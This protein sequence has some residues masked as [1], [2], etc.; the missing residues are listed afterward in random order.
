MGSGEKDDKVN[1]FDGIGIYKDYFYWKEQKIECYYCP[2]ITKD[3]IDNV[4]VGKDGIY[5]NPTDE[6]KRN[7]PSGDYSDYECIFSPDINRNNLNVQIVGVRDVRTALLL[8]SRYKFDMIFCD[9][10]L[11]KKAENSEERDYIKQLFEFLSHN[12]K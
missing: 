12:Y 10:L 7:R 11:D 5:V 4:G 8:M 9:Y 2:T 6:E 3:F 1:V